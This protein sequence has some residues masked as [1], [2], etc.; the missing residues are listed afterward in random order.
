MFTLSLRAMIG[1]PDYELT[2]EH[3]IFS[4]VFSIDYL[5]PMLLNK[6]HL[7]GHPLPNDVSDCSASSVRTINTPRALACRL[8][9]P[10]Y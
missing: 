6:D 1:T 8:G 9:I 7:Y 10:R 2:I 4:F 3:S 5:A